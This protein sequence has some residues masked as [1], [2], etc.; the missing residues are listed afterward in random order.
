MSK[1]SKFSYVQ[2]R[3][4]SRYGQR[5]DENVWLRLHNIHDLSSY[6][7]VAQQTPLRQWVIG[8]NSIHSSHEIELALRQKYRKHIDEVTGWMP[9]AWQQPVQWIKRLADL[10]VLQYLLAGGVPSHWM[11]SDPD[12][13]EFTADDPALRLQAM[14]D[15]GCAT[16]VTAWQQDKTLSTGWLSDWQAMHPRVTAFTA[17]MQTLELL[18]QQQ[19]HLQLAAEAGQAAPATTSQYRVVDYESIINKLRLLFR[20]HAFQPAAVYAYL[21]I[22]AM[23]LHRVRSDLLQRLLFK[24]NINN[25][26][27][28]N[29]HV[30][31]SSQ[32]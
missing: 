11:K 21:T 6:L 32:S 31:G 10:P 15:A 8:I 26:F 1:L 12:I 7:Q 3:L 25:D 23:D 18:L 9:A 17:G 5:A 30:A 14:A 22:I 4:Q 24:Q 28:N 19:L 27:N 20:H 16:L 29:I 13:R 2:V